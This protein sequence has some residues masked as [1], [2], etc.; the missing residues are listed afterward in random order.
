M[1]LA[2]GTLILLAGL[3]LSP[4]VLAQ[5]MSRAERPELKIGD[6]WAYQRL[7]VR[8]GEKRGA[9][10][11]I[12][13]A[14]SDE[15]IVVQTKALDRA[16][17]EMSGTN[18]YTRDW[19]LTEVKAG[20]TVS[21]TAR[22]A[23]GYYKFPL[24][25]GQQWE[26]NFAT[27]SLS[28]TASGVKGTG[29]RTSRWQWKVRVEGVE[30]VTVPAGTFDALKLRYEGNFDTTDGPRRWSGTRTETLWYAPAVK[31]HVKFEHETRTTSAVGSSYDHERVELLSFKP[32]P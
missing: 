1:R 6:T 28:R 29:E 5:S 3:L 32:A 18:S 23:W 26:A 17:R 16:G 25:V 10:T 21:F 20:D 14:L 8:T 24:E 31:R 7:D 9:G 4:S 19:N 2:N 27:T 15:R 22:P 11:H 12:L 30:S 13:E